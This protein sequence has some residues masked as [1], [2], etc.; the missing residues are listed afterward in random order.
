MKKTSLRFRVAKP[1]RIKTIL[2]RSSCFP[3]SKENMLKFDA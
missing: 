3:K 1:L 2:P